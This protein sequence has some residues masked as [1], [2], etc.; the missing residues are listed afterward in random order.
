MYNPDPI[1]CPRCGTRT[2]V[3]A[4][5]PGC[6]SMDNDARSA[7]RRQEEH[8]QRMEESAKRMEEQ[9]RKRSRQ[10]D[11][12]PNYDPH[13]FRYEFRPR[14]EAEREADMLAYRPSFHFW[15]FLLIG[16]WL[17]IVIVLFSIKYFFFPIFIFKGFRKVLYA[18]AGYF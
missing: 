10:P 1:A 2:F 16:W 18:F 17:A 7:R 13:D 12:D 5:C 4:G 8:F 6:L 11:Y 15:Y 14:T 9:S 3:G